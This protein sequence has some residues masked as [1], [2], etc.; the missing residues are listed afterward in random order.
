MA[1]HANSLGTGRWFEFPIRRNLDDHPQ[2]LLTVVIP[3]VVLE[4]HMDDARN[5]YPMTYMN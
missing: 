2:G 1:H 4:W 3:Q 5:I